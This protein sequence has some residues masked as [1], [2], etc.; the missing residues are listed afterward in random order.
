MAGLTPTQRTL[1]ALR[2]RGA[3]CASVEKWNPYGG[4]HGVRVDLFGFIDLVLIDPQYGIVAIQSCGEAFS[5][6][7]KKIVENEIAP[8]WMKHGRI[9][10]WAWRKV[11]RVRGGKAM[12]WK[13][14]I[15]IFQVGDFAT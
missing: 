15:H 5:A 1:K 14:K 7:Y 9:E 12:M 3:I 4:P 11:K 13:P 10:L 8:E 2:E 6:H